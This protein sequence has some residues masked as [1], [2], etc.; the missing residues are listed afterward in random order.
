MEKNNKCF[1]IFSLILLAFSC[2]ILYN[3]FLEFLS[4]DDLDIT[5]YGITTEKVLA[6][7]LFFIYLFNAWQSYKYFSDGLDYNFNK[8]IGIVLLAF[9]F[10]SIISFIFI[11]SSEEKL[12]LEFVNEVEISIQEENSKLKKSVNTNSSTINELIDLMSESNVETE[13]GKSDKYY[14]RKI[15]IATQIEN[16]SILNRYFSMLIYNPFYEYYSSNKVSSPGYHSL[17]FD[18]LNYLFF[19]Y[20]EVLYYAQFQLISISS[21]IGSIFY[22][23]HSKNRYTTNDI[24]YSQDQQ[25][26]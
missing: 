12:A 15:A 6:V 23:Y 2:Y 18:D 22:L 17:I 7:I 13:Y 19:H 20:G 14:E 9:A 3:I 21:I 25:K 4:I 8:K 5:G 11:R 1:F 10:I 24:F 26:H 16:S